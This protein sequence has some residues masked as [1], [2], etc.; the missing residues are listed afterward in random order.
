MQRGGVY[1]VI[2]KQAETTYEHTPWPR[3]PWLILEAMS[4]FLILFNLNKN[5][6]TVCDLF[7]YVQPFDQ[8]ELKS[9]TVF[10]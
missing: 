4:Q 2:W 6:I 3:L 10:F 7:S 9:G 8:I 5:Q 1:F